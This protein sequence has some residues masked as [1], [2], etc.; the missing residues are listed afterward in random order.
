MITDSKDSIT[1]GSTKNIIGCLIG[2]G[3]G[4]GAAYLVA[5]IIGLVL[6]LILNPLFRDVPG[7]NSLVS[8]SLT[9]CTCLTSIGLA[10]TISL[11][12]TRK[13]PPFLRKVRTHMQNKAR[14]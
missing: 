10:L 7:L 6:P 2:Q 14:G 5:Q 4:C 3:L 8:V 11:L 1:P 12:V 9:G 13:F